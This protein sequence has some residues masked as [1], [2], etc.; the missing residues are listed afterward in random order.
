MQ[1]IVLYQSDKGL[2]LAGDE[3]ICLTFLTTQH[4]AWSMI[5]L[6][7]RT[8]PRIKKLFPSIKF[9]SLSFFID[10]KRVHFYDMRLSFIPPI[11]LKKLCMELELNE[12]GLRIA[13]IDVHVFYRKSKQLRKV[14]HHVLSID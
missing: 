5:P 9:Y 14:S 4:S 3:I 12:Y 1:E 13:D 2:K 8:Y 11:K 10:R 7:I 6:M